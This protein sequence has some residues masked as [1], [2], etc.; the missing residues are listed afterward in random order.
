MTSLEHTRPCIAWPPAAMPHPLPAEIRFKWNR[1]GFIL[2]PVL[3]QPLVHKLARDP[4]DSFICVDKPQPV[5]VGCWNGQVSGRVKICNMGMHKHAI[6]QR[7]G[8]FD[9]PVR[10]LRIN[11]Y[12]L[13]HV[14][15][16]VFYARDNV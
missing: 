3:L 15:P 8:D 14:R 9:S 4:R 5:V 10:A 1:N 13:G 11:E 2:V 12:D 7:S 6:N 16:E